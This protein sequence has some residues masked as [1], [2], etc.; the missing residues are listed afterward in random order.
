MANN[1]ALFFDTGKNKM[2]FSEVLTEVQKFLARKYASLI[3]NNPEE[4]RRQITAYIAKYIADNRYGVEGLDNDTLVERLYSEM[5]EFSF[6]TKYLF[7]PD[8][9][10]LNINSWKDVK[11]TY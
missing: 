6:L 4:Q 3:T 7:A 8:V 5:A 11:I 9:E 10:E 2:E 1:I